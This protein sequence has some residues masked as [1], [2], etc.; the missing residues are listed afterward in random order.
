[1]DQ[2]NQ[3]ARF[4]NAEKKG[5]PIISFTYNGKQRNGQINT[6]GCRNPLPWGHRVPDSHSV[7]VHNG[8][9]YVLVQE[10]NTGEIERPVK[11]FKLSE[12]SNISI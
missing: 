11:I 12:M 3:A 9:H 1:M 2:T 4:V 7:V 6:L 5:A 10:N 8:Q